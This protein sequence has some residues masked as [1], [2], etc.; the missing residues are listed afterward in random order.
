MPN[1]F[2]QVLHFPSAFKQQKNNGKVL[3]Q[4]GFIKAPKQHYIACGNT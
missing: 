3:I 2:K 4:T 1:K